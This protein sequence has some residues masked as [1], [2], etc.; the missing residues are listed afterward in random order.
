M[1]ECCIGP[2]RR[3]MTLGAIMR[4]VSGRMIRV[5]RLLVLRL[6]TLIAIAVHQMII[7]ARVT[8]LTLRCHM[9]SRQREIRRGMIERCTTP[10][11]SGMTLRAIMI[12]IPGDVVGICSLLEI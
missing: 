10:V 6:M 3:G 12:E 5:R 8:L 2:V 4:E 7:A 9:R 11:N 1:I